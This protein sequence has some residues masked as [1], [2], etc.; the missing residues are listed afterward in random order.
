MTPANHF[1][2]E[3]EAKNATAKP[4]NAFPSRPLNSSRC[5]PRDMWTVPPSVSVG[6]SFCISTDTMI[7]GCRGKD[8]LNG[9]SGRPHLD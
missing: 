8:G 3:R 6:A 7:P 5:P 4:P 2:A 9:V 1:P